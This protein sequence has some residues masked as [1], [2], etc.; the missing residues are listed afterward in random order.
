MVALRYQ[1]SDGSAR[2]NSL[3]ILPSG[4]LFKCSRKQCAGKHKKHPDAQPA[5]IMN[6]LQVIIALPAY[7]LAA[8][9]QPV[10]W[11]DADHARGVVLLL[12]Y[13]SEAAIGLI[14]NKPT[15]V[16]ISEVLPEAKGRSVAVYA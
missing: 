15:P 9:S 5:Y 13:D 2:T 11:H 6:H 1:D 4:R 3:D 14:L 10:K 8:S 12:H 7:A 16:S